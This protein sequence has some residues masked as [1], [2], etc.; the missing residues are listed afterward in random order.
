MRH[1]L[2][3]LCLS[4]FLAGC[5]APVQNPV[6]GRS[7][8]SVMSLSDEIAAGRKAHEQVLRE[9]GVY[10]DPRL[11]AYVEEIGQRLARQSHRSDLRWTFSL[12]D[13]PEVNAFAAPGGYVYVTRGL[14]AHMNSEADLAGVIG[15]EIGHVTARHSA[16]RATREQGAGLGVL[17]ASVLGMVLESQGL[18]GAGQLAGELSQTAAAGYVASYSRDQELQADRLGAEYLA[19]SN[20]DPQHMVDVIAV[21][22]AQERFAADAARSEGRS[23]PAQTSW[24]SSHPTNERRLQDIRQHAAQLAAASGR[25]GAPENRSRYLQA[26]DGLAF[27]E[28]PEQGL[29]RGQNFYHEPLG[30]GLSAPRGWTIRNSAESVAV[31]NAERDAGLLVKAVPPQSGSHDDILRNLL[32]AEQGRAERFS[33]NGLEATR[34]TGSGRDSRGQ[35]QRLD[36]TL[37]TGPTR[38]VFVLL[39]AGRDDA[40]LQR[41]QR[42]LQE[43]IGSFRP[44]TSADRIAARPWVLRT[45]AFPRGGFVELARQSPLEPRPDPQLRLINGVYQGGAEPRPGELVKSVVAR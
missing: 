13:S 5:G 9:Y 28:S 4:S 2:I 29:T 21:L 41:A 35:L 19:R 43:A 17:A 14:M 26:I 38:Q 44:L 34:W 6:T 31:L 42:P 1:A 23:A 18:A 25:R 16:Q 10:R 40:A 7:E 30:I 27:G 20:Y 15:H 3:G 36:A 37:V 39:P 22:Q 33:L 45:V 12:L 8:R 32:K 11:Q 24:L